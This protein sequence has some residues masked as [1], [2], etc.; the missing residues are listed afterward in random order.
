MQNLDSKPVRHLESCMW[1]RDV[2]PQ[3]LQGK[4]LPGRYFTFGYSADIL[5]MSGMKRSINGTAVELLNAMTGLE[6]SVS[7][8][9]SCWFFVSDWR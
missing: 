1:P 4:N 9:E 2:L 7:L 6:P 3:Y 8:E 5:N